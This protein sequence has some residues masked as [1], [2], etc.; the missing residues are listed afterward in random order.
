MVL[1][2]TSE[3]LPS[4]SVITLTMRP[5]DWE[6]Q[7]D[8]ADSDDDYRGDHPVSGPSPRLG[9]VRIESP[10]GVEG[11]G[12]CY[13]GCN[14]PPCVYRVGTLVVGPSHSGILSGHVLVVIEPRRL[15]VRRG[16]GLK[17]LDVPRWPRAAT[18]RDTGAS[19]LSI[20]IARLRPCIKMNDRAEPQT[21]ALEETQA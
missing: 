13:A 10:G 19:A 21:P 4:H 7:Q 14:R 16:C 15:W 6:G 9:C 1:D 12:N 17:A 20:L 11:A 5:P 2:A 18:M 3:H 8:E